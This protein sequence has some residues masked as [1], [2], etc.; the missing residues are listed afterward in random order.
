MNMNMNHSKVNKFQGNKLT[1][2]YP[3]T[4]GTI[5]MAVLAFGLLFFANFSLAQ[6][7]NENNDKEVKTEK[8]KQSEV[9]VKDSKPKDTERGVTPVIVILPKSQNEDKKG[10]G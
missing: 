9:E 5:K 7:T 4:Q 8:E 2:C 1:K 6:T 10:K 3:A